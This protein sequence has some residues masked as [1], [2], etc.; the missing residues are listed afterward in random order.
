M[1]LTVEFNSVT[2]RFT[3]KHMLWFPKAYKGQYYVQDLTV[4]CGREL[5]QRDSSILRRPCRSDLVNHRLQV[6]S[7]R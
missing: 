4:R 6:L 3:A 2:L 7:L 5:V 1:M